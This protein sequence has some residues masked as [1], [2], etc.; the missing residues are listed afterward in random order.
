[1]YTSYTCVPQARRQGGFMVARKP[2]FRPEKWAGYTT[3]CAVMRRHAG[4]SG[5]MD[6]RVNGVPGFTSNRS[7]LAEPGLGREGVA[8]QATSSAPGLPLASVY[9]I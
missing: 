4:R 2:P 5:S 8:G 7:S 3:R 9:V 6:I 1:M